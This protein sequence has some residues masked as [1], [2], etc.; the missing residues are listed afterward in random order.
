MQELARM[1]ASLVCEDEKG[2]HPLMYAVRW[3]HVECL[4]E[5]VNLSQRTE[6]IDLVNVVDGD[7]NRRTAIM[8]AA[9]NMQCESVRVLMWTELM[10]MA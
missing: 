7:P 3:G 8:V 9:K 2:A 6:G 5:L 10:L 4:R 1:G